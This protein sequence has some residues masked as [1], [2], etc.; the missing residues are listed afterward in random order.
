MVEEPRISELH[1]R[2]QQLED[3]LA[4]RRDK[5]HQA[6]GLEPHH[7]RE[8]EEIS[9]QAQAMRAKLS[10]ASQAG[11]DP[12]KHEVEADWASLMGAFERWVR[13]VDKDYGP[14]N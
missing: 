1:K 4:E 9:S 11:W 7:H 12:M 10:S 2:L 8:A 5:L 3:E 14:G 6:G 13:H